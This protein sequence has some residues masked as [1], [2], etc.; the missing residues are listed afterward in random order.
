[1]DE[2]VKQLEKSLELKVLLDNRVKLIETFKSVDLKKLSKKLLSHQILSKSTSLAFN[3]MDDNVDAKVKARFLFQQIYRRIQDKSDRYDKLL[4]VISESEAGVNDNLRI[5]GTTIMNQMARL[6]CSTDEKEWLAEADILPLMNTLSSCEDKWNRIGRSLN[7]PQSMIDSIDKENYTLND[8]LCAVLNKWL[9]GNYAPMTLDRLETVL[10]TP[11]VHENTLAYNLKDT[12]QNFKELLGAPATKR[13]KLEPSFSIEYQ[14]TD[15]EVHDGKS[16]I[17]EV[18]VNSCSLVTYQWM[19]DNEPLSDGKVYS[20]TDNDILLVHRAYQDTA[21]SYI[22]KIECPGEHLSTQAIILSV[23]YSKEKNRLLN[24]Y[25][26]LSEI[27]KDSWFLPTTSKFINLA[28]I[29]ES[30]QSDNASRH[31][32]MGDFS[33]ILQRKEKVTYDQVFGKYESGAFILVEGR[34]GSGKTTLACKI[35]RDWARKGNVLQYVEHVFLLPLRGYKNRSTVKELFHSMLNKAKENDGQSFCFIL[36]GLDEWQGEQEK[37]DKIEELLQM[38]TVPNA[39]LIVTSRPAKTI[40]YRDKASKRIEVLGFSTEHIYEYVE[41]YSFDKTPKLNEL[42][43]T[44]LKTY[45]L[46]HTNLLY[47]CYLPVHAAMIC[48]LYKRFQDS[49]PQTETQIYEHFTCAVILRKLQQV[50]RSAQLKQLSGLDDESSKNFKDICQLAFDMVC[51]S[52]Q[53]VNTT[54]LPFD[55]QS[56]SFSLLTMDKIAESYGQEGVIT[57][58]HFTHQEYL[59]AYHIAGM[60]SEEQT[61]AIIKYG[62]SDNMLATWK[63]YCGISTNSEGNMSHFE[64]LM[65]A[66]KANH[67]YKI[68]CAY[69]S[70]EKLFCNKIAELLSGTFSFNS[71]VIT[72]GDFTAIKFLLENTTHPLFSF[73]MQMCTS[74]ELQSESK[75]LESVE[76]SDLLYEATPK[77]TIEKMVKIF[78][79]IVDKYFKLSSKHRKEFMEG[80]KKAYYGL[81]SINLSNFGIDPSTI[82]DLLGY[83]SKGKSTILTSEYAVPLV[84]ALKCPTLNLSR[85]DLSSNTFGP[86]G[87]AIIASIIQFRSNLQ[88][89]NISVNLIGSEGAKYLSD[90]IRHFTNLEYLNLSANNIGF[91]GEKAVADAIQHIELQIFNISWNSISTVQLFEY[92]S[93]LKV[94]NLAATNIEA[95]CKRG[96]LVFSSTLE[97]LN[98]SQNSIDC[99][100]AIMVAK[101]L[102]PCSELT[103]LILSCNFIGY[104]GAEAIANIVTFKVQV[105]NLSRNQIGEQCSAIAKKLDKFSNLKLD[106]RHNVCNSLD[107]VEG[108]EVADEIKRLV[109][110]LAD[111]ES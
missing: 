71:H 61:Q 49:M 107:R 67:L 16:V 86:E 31:V 26:K 56:P 91:E 103:K 29:K 34:P 111:H 33:T 43:V 41:A 109:R 93:K 2:S 27:A 37:D 24:R 38:E 12:F 95:A 8:K 6:G 54:D 68:Q 35:A 88:G 108:Q 20:N 96:E 13:I 5:M 64:N 100:G 50:N 78:P 97:E 23:S 9:S 72:P 53:T 105:L 62:A 87:A 32:A 99:E 17:L 28:L 7:L 3:S 42:M 90:G 73:S 80:A 39:M 1:M 48:F 14:S 25:A 44:K 82:S 57:F 58:L 18:S 60:T 66:M 51:D 40:D 22:C 94:L 106:M 76:I 85:L 98:L 77:K 69:E 30:G 10:N 47:M 21:G 79:S 70:Q 75:E 81:L 65:K 55:S 92:Q 83:F 4:S 59:A 45:L 101:A 84:Q 19:K 52:R 110:Y 102:K 74:H 36:D 15:I 46:L 11:H 63:F 89:L 104:K